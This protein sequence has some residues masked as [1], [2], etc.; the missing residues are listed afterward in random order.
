MK[1]VITTGDRILDLMRDA[2]THHLHYDYGEAIALFQ[3]FLENKPYRQRHDFGKKIR[4]GVKL[5]HLRM[6]GMYDGNLMVAWAIQ[7]LDVRYS[8]TGEFW[9]YTQ[10]RHRLQGYQKKLVNS[11]KKYEEKA[12]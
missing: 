9:R 6:A 7:W 4:S 12:A 2:V 3:A 10:T 5:S 8:V 11:L 1:V